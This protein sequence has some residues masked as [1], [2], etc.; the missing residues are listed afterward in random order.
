MQRNNSLLFQLQQRAL[1]VAF[2]VHL[3]LALLPLLLF[4]K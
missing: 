4:K 3:Q 2:C 1:V